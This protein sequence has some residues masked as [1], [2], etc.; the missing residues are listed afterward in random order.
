MF[1]SPTSNLRRRRLLFAFAL[2]S[3]ALALPESLHAQ[4]AAAAPRVS[5]RATKRVAKRAPRRARQLA[6][7]QR[8]PRRTK[9]LLIAARAPRSNA[10]RAVNSALLARNAAAPVNRPAPLP[11]IAP[12]PPNIDPFADIARESDAGNTL[13]IDFTRTELV[14][15]AKASAQVA[16]RG[17]TLLVRMDA[18]DLPDPTYFDVPRYAL[19]VYVPNYQ[20]K[21]YIGDLPITRRSKSAVRGKDGSPSLGASYSAYRYTIL[22]PEAEF[23]GLMLT[24]EPVRYTPIVNEALRPVLVALTPQADVQAAVAAPTYYAGPLPKDLT[25]KPSTAPAQPR[26][27]NR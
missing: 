14:N 16:L 22:P 17:Q 19:W 6:R 5:K 23:G 15:K 8:S 24:A 4:Q 11:S 9:R 3:L 7:A 26:Q 12:L 27:N 2:L 10:R 21:L 25:K 13:K 1:T 20:V 18:K